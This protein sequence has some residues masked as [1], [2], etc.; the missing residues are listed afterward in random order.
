[1]Q[2]YDLEK[3]HQ[4]IA[5]LYFGDEIFAYPTDTVFGI[6][7]NPQSSIAAQK[8]IKLKHRNP[9]KGLIVL[10]AEFEQIEIYLSDKLNLDDKQ[11]IWRKSSEKPTTFIFNSSGNAAKYVEI[12][13]KIAIRLSANKFI[14]K[15]CKIFNGAIISTSANLSGKSTLQDSSEIKATFPDLAIISGTCEAYQPSRIIDFATGEIIR[16]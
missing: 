9:N 4:E 1:M 10:A 15:L 14:Q 3:H 13:G 11:K 16:K 6:G 12:N 8:I 5:D 2:I 7:G